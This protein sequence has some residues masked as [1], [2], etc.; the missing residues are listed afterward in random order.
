MWKS[1]NSGTSW[2]VLS[3]WS[4][5]GATYVH[6]DCHDLTF[7][8]ST[9][10]AGN[11]GGVFSSA[12]SGTTWTDRSSNLSI[13]QLYGMGTSQT[14]ANL[15]IAGHQDNGTT[16][17]SNGT[18]WAEVNG[19]DGMLCF[20]DRT[21]NTRM[22]SSIYNGDLY[23]STNS[24]SSFSSIYTVAG[25]GW[26]TPWLQDPVTSTTLYA[27][28][29]NVVRSTNSGTSWSTISSFSIGTI[30]SL[31]VATTNAQ[32]IIAASN[33]AVMRTTN[34]GTAWTNITSG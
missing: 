2:S 30:V 22:F 3:H 16:L 27:G 13:A 29:T 33:T 7:I 8:G 28:G 9:L 5:S 10:Y 23:R 26:V 21:D 31:D 20:I 12:N 19:G 1:T 6:A 4:G 24:G 18:T 17:T 25:G 14:N 11:D 32:H 34:G 15:I